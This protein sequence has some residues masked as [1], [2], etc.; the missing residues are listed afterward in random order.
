MKKIN[1][2]ISL[3]S[4]LF[5]Q[6]VNGQTQENEY[7]VGVI[8]VSLIMPDYV[9]GF[10][11]ANLSRL[12]NKILQIL[13]SNGLSGNGYHS[14]FVVFPKIEMLGKDEIPGM[15]T[16][17]SVE[18]ELNLF[19]KQLDNNIMFSSFSKTLKGM[20]TNEKRA[21]NSAINKIP[22]HSK[23][24]KAFMAET[25]GR[26]ISYYETK[27]DDIILEAS[28]Y[29]QSQQYEKAIA[30]LATIPSEMSDCY[31]KA[32]GKAVEY[33]KAYSDQK[34]AEYLQKSLAAEAS[35]DY[36]VAL[37]YLSLIDASGNCAKQSQELIQ[38]IAVKV[39]VKVKKY[40]DF[41]IK[42]YDD[43]QSLKK[44]RLDAIVEISKAYYTRTQPTNHITYKSLF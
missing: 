13:T 1:L 18:V 21:I 16:M 20:S 7:D 40:W 29:S 2:I 10:S 27:C 11:S 6:T 9:E 39:D 15:Q 28:R 17:V 24:V 14:N 19:V 5:F 36:K 32:Q 25:K 44:S 26:I 43:N 34:C 37:K 8:S 42:R 33:Y 30:T 22:T 41:L 3:V 23:D 12:E 31:N 4:L 38:K 35:Q